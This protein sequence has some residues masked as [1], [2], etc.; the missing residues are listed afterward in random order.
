[1]QEFTAKMADPLALTRAATNTQ[2]MTL[3]MKNMWNERKQLKAL[4][5]EAAAFEMVLREQID[6]VFLVLAHLGEA[7][8]PLGVFNKD[9]YLQTLGDVQAAIASCGNE[10]LPM[11]WA[12]LDAELQYVCTAGLAF[13]ACYAPKPVYRGFGACVLSDYD[14]ACPDMAYLEEKARK[15]AIWTVYGVKQRVDPQ[16]TRSIFLAFDHAIQLLQVKA[17]AFLEK[18]PL[19]TGFAEHSPR[20]GAKPKRDVKDNLEILEDWVRALEREGHPVPAGTRSTSWGVPFATWSSPYSCR[21]MKTK[22]DC[23]TIAY[24][25]MDPGRLLHGFLCRGNA[26]LD[27]GQIL[28]LLPGSPAESLLC[29]LE[30]LPGTSHRIVKWQNLDITSFEKRLSK[31]LRKKIGQYPLP[32]QFAIRHPQASA[33]SPLTATRSSPSVLE[34]P[35]TVSPPP[36]SPETARR[37][38]SLQPPAA[39]LGSPE[40]RELAVIPSTSQSAQRSVMAG[41]PTL[42]YQLPNNIARLGA[43]SGVKSIHNLRRKASGTPTAMAASSPGAVAASGG[44]TS[45]STSDVRTDAAESTIPEL[46]GAH[47]I[48]EAPVDNAEIA[49]ELPTEANTEALK[50]DNSI[51]SLQPKEVTEDSP[52]QAKSPPVE[53][54]PEVPELAEQ[55]ME[56]GVALTGTNHT[57]VEPKVHAAS[58]PGEEQSKVGDKGEAIATTEQFTSTGETGVPSP[59]EQPT[60]GAT[61]D[62]PTIAENDTVNDGHDE[63]ADSFAGT[64][65]AGKADSNTA[66][67]LN[68]YLDLLNKVAK[69]EISPQALGEMLQ[70]SGIAQ[71]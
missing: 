4:S 67:A 32:T 29:W 16:P 18:R 26:N 55:R 9:Y 11:A 50:S 52:T 15:K 63:S 30:G 5:T 31:S 14:W 10:L 51:T 39:E 61:P 62:V 60:Q 13:C 37:G 45:P 6:E 46:P 54:G 47:S 22:A 21:I 53:R 34:H 43:S 58:A 44:M 64:S 71:T 17:L 3:A 1:M 49:V 42:A 68:P 66:T 36:Y 19:I 25:Q 8:L 41:V 23:E 33:R 28:M 40:P 59:L 35:N 69:G 7:I 38:E 65:D 48:A 2:K 70:K 56:S 20:F 24:H 27:D 57:K 12:E